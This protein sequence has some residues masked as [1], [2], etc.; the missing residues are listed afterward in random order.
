M[1]RKSSIDKLP[2]E[3]REAL[4]AWL[5]DAALTQEETTD[6]TNTLLAEIGVDFRISKS[7]VNRYS[8]RMEQIGAKIRQSREVSEMWIANLGSQPQGQL[9]KLINEMIRT[10]AFEASAALA[11]S[12]DPVPPKILKD[13]A[14]A[15]QR[16]ESAANMNEDRER[17]V[18]AEERQRVVEEA[19]TKVEQAGNQGGM[20]RESI[21]TIKREI[22]GI[23]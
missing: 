21:D 10:M 4:N 22:L 19:A 15:V 16:L 6:R 23:R 17:K 1:G 9:G 5:R 20:S 14:L 2:Q 8:Q 13:L 11:E 12:G 7:A 18:R 3:V